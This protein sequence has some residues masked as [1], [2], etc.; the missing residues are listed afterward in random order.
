MGK[1]TAIEYCDSTVN[2]VVGCIGCELFHPHPQRN[3]CYA[4]ALCRRFAGQRGWPA[5][6]RTPEHFPGRIEQALS[7]PDLTGQDRPD[8]P[9]LNKMPRLVF[10]N[11]LSDGFGA[12]GTRGIDPEI[13]LTPHLDALQASPHIWLFLTKWPAQ[14]VDY[15][16]AHYHQRGGVPANFWLGTSI[17]RQRTAHHR[18]N[19]LADINHRSGTR[20]TRLWWSVEPLLEQVRFWPHQLAA[21]HWVVTGGESGLSARI[22]TPHAFRVLRDQC[23]THGVPF[24][25]KQWGGVHSMGWVF[26]NELY[27]GRT[28]D[29][30]IWSQMPAP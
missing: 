11:D 25:F 24:F 14:M 1:H 7:W 17:T 5:D 16:W 4:A 28:L 15:F 20:H 18:V 27:A 13:W 30:Q 10:V 23:Q 12:N 26:D 19:Q 9:W 8:K 21:V 22:P 2:P 6:F 29:G 3:H